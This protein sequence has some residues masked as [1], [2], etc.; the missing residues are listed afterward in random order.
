MSCKRLYSMVRFLH[1]C[2]RAY[3]SSRK[4]FFLPACCAACMSRKRLYSKCKRVHKKRKSVRSLRTSSSSAARQKNR[5]IDGARTRDLHLGKVAYY[6]LYYYRTLCFGIFYISRT[7]LILYT[8][9]LKLST[10]FLIFFIVPFFRLIEAILTHFLLFPLHF[11]D[12]F[13]ERYHNTF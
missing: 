4:T 10:V 5:A 11:C 1:L 3:Y 6:Q 7:Q 8:K 12:N 13:V 9:K 2:K